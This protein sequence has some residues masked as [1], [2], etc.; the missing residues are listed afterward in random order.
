MS[1]LQWLRAMICWGSI[2]GKDRDRCKRET[3]ETHVT[4]RLKP[5][6]KTEVCCLVPPNPGNPLLQIFAWLMWCRTPTQS[7]P[8]KPLSE[9]LFTQSV[10]Q[11]FC[12]FALL[13]LYQAF[14]VPAMP[15]NKTPPQHT[16]ATHHC[17]TPWFMKHERSAG[18]RDAAGGDSVSFPGHDHEPRTANHE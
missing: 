12:A 3:R 18:P 11:R 6:W 14:M 10:F 16:T 1:V 9:N 5:F 17:D 15:H 4:N 7:A 8:P 13:P 2:L